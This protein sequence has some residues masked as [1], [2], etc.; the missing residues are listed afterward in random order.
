MRFQF[1][2]Q[3]PKG[4]VQSDVFTEARDGTDAGMPFPVGFAAGIIFQT[5]PQNSLLNLV[6]GLPRIV[7]GILGATGFQQITRADRCRLQ[8]IVA[9][10][11]GTFGK[12]FR[13]GRRQTFVGVT[14]KSIARNCASSGALNLGICH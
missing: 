14:R 9:Q 8:I 2:G 3:V 12:G 10:Q 7:A 1:L 6:V 5:A 11:D 13:F 4:F